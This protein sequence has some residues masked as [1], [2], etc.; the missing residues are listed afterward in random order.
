MINR[1][2][3]VLID[4]REPDEWL[5]GHAPQARHL[6]L[7][8]LRAD[9]LPADRPIIL[10]CRSGNRSRQAADRLAAAGIAVH[11]LTGGMTAWAR[12]GQPVRTDDGQ[13]GTVR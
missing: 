10:V 7:G 12:A 9:L 8:Q 5:A 3:A 4:I 1:G 2:E 13:P 11:D 6:P